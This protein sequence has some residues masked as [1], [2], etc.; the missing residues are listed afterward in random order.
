[1]FFKYRKIPIISPGLI[2]VQTAFLLGLFSGSL[3][4]EGLIIGRNF[5]FQ[6]GLGLTIKTASINSPWAYI[7][8]GLLS[9]GFVRLRFGG[10]I[11]GRAY[12]LGGLIGILRYCSKC[13]CAMRS[14]LLINFWTYCSNVEQNLS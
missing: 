10:L 8:E 3:F 12:F 9:E 5:A 11:F 14:F 2:F 7:W 1:M 6:N 4:L 13:Y